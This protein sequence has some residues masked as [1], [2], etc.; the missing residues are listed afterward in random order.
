MAGIV[1]FITF[2]VSKTGRAVN[3]GRAADV[4]RQILEATG[5]DLYPWRCSSARARR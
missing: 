4:P 5:V 2:A 1:V 3:C